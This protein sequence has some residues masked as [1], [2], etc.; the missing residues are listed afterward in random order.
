MSEEVSFSPVHVQIVTG[1]VLE[2][3]LNKVSLNCVTKPVE[4]LAILQA[5]YPRV[6]GTMETSAALPCPA[7]AGPP[8]AGSWS[9][10]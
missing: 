8:P 2:A 4:S 1:L 5:T 9:L 10:L 7:C 3:S 6:T